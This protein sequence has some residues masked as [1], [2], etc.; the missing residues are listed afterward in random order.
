MP[1]GPEHHS[2]MDA[3]CGSS[4][5]CKTVNDRGGD[6]QVFKPF[7]KALLSVTVLTV[8]GIGTVLAQAPTK[9]VKDQGEYDLF[10]E[11][12]KTTD[13]AKR[14]SLLNTWTQK[15]PDTAFK[16]ERWKYYAVTYQQLGQ[17]AKMAEAAKEI[18][19]IN[20][21]EV[22]R[23]EERRVGKECRSRWSPYH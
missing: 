6:T 10:T 2:A 16:E 15:Y 4:L 7:A 21:K 9:Q 11:V 23:S 8:M 1:L 13:A 18:L 12:G 14:L 17:G 22:N 3:T 19:A 5:N 20:P